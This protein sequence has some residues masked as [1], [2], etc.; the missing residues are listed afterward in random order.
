MTLLVDKLTPALT[1]FRGARMRSVVTVHGIP[2][3]LVLLTSMDHAR[4][5]APCVVVVYSLLTME[6]IF[7]GGDDYIRS[8][9]KL[10]GPLVSSTLYYVQIFAP[11]LSRPSRL[12]LPLL[13]TPTVN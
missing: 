11:A 9:P 6:V 3:L 10:V 12:Y 13:S 7:A 1:H 4:R 2:I 8:R 5:L